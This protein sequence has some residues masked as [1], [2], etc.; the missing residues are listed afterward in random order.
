MATGNAKAALKKNI[1]MMT[2]V[3]ALRLLY[4]DES[5]AIE[6]RTDNGVAIRLKSNE[7]KS[8]DRPESSKVTSRGGSQRKDGVQG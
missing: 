6:S 3:V 5:Q 7:A 8:F 2:P 1:A 4:A